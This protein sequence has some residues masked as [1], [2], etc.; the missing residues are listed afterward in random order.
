[1]LWSEIKHKSKCILYIFSCQQDIEEG[2]C[3]ENKNTEHKVYNH[4]IEYVLRDRTPDELLKSSINRKKSFKYEI[5]L[6]CK[7]VVND[8]QWL[9]RAEE[10]NLIQTRSDTNGKTSHEVKHKNLEADTL[11]E[12]MWGQIKH[13][14]HE[15]SE[16]EILNVVTDSYMR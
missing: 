2:I 14:L 10:L 16:K 8:F 15:K 11:V 7:L 13:F 12:M 6:Q 5:V 3:E 1:M 4:E 9:S